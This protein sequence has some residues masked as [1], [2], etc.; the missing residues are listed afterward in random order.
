M[1]K[2]VT[3]SIRLFLTDT[4]L[5]V[6]DK[7]EIELLE[8]NIRGMEK[9]ILDTLESVL[10]T[11]R[12]PWIVLDL[13]ESKGCRFRLRISRSRV[14]SSN[15]EPESRVAKLGDYSAE[16]FRVFTIGKPS[17]LQIGDLTIHLP[18]RSTSNESVNA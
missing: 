14:G 8:S 11:V 17:V 1:I 9:Q 7:Q 6:I 5:Y 10:R 13:F 15:G 2:Q 16:I 12:V 18:N 4:A 3:P